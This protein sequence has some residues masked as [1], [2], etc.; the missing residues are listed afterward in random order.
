MS[1]RLLAAVFA[2]CLVASAETMSV[3]QLIAFVESSAKFIKQGMMTDKELASFLAKTKLTDRL[4]DRTI[5]NLQGS[6][7]GQKTLDELHRLRDETKALTVAKLP[8]PP[9]QAPPPSSLRQAAILDGVR[10]YALN[11]SR[12]LPDFICTQVTRRYASPRRLNRQ[13][14]ES[15]P[16]WQTMDVITTRLSYFEQK[17]SYKTI[18]INNTPTSQDYYNLGGSTV[19][20]D[21]GS[22]MRDI[23]ER[24]TQARFEWE[25]WATLRGR[26]MMV[27]AYRVDQSRSKW[28]ISYE[29]SMDIVPAYRG[30]VYVDNDTHEVMRITLEA[31]NLPPAFPVR[32][33]RMTLDYRYEEIADRRFLLPYVS[34]TI[35]TGESY[36]TRNDTEFRLYRKYSAESEIKFETET[37]PALP[38]D[39]LMETP[40]SAPAP[41]K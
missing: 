4:D 20:G 15:E 29:R 1:F 17:E 40:A 3:E 23:F 21:F 5:E 33:F 24:S 27:F 12:G 28:H 30:L 11:Y 41:K 13:G 2:L 37:P 8:E 32:S 31:E 6:G 10:E 18:L 7:I 26:L 36:L 38:E 39:Q 25:R 14:Q 9:R 35:M 19:T 22:M 16:E 34:R